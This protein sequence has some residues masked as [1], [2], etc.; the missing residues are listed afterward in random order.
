MEKDESDLLAGPKMQYRVSKHPG[1]VNRVRAC[2]Q[3]RQLVCTMSDDGHS[4]IWDI[5]KQLLALENQDASG[6]EKANP[7]F[8]NKLHGNE[9]Y[10]VGWNRRSIG[11]LATGD[12]CG[13]LVLWKP[14]Q[15]GWDLSDI[16][17]NVHL[18]SVEDIQWQPN[19]NQSDQ[20]FATASADG[21]IRIFDLRSNTTG[22][23]ITIT[24]QP[25]NDVNSI[26]WNPHKCEMLL[27]GEENGGAFVWD[28]RHADVPL[29]TLMWHNK[30]ITSVSWHPVEQS[31]CACAAR[32]DSI[33]IWDLSVEAEAKGERVL[34]LEGKKGIPEQLMFLHMGQTEITEL[35]YH[36]LIPGVIV[37]TAS[38]SLNIFK[39][40]NV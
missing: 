21:Q 12:T 1:I 26:S 4:Y 31:V 17:G 28:I 35:A 34:K 20:I 2:P 25:I 5:S 16:Y 3:A 32:D 15:G 11:M 9:G 10:A 37:S 14:I 40:A 27:S 19:A 30:A 8:T 29:A 6:S 13:S 39:C 7:L 23:T 24:S 38:D 22:P 36:P 18:K 33:S